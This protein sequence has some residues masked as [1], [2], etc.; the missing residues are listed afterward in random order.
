MARRHW[1]IAAQ[2][3]GL[4][5]CMCISA[6]QALAAAKA[7]SDTLVATKAPRIRLS[8]P[9]EMAPAER[10]RYEKDK[11]RHTNLARLLSLAPAL[12]PQLQ[13]FNTAMATGIAIPPLEREI[14]AFAVLNM[15]RG[16]WEL[17][18][19][20]EVVKIMGIPQAKVD[21][22]VEER[23]GDPSFTD[24]ERALLAFTRQV[25][26]SVRVDDPTFAAVAAF[27]DRRQIVETIMVITNYMGLA[28]LSEVA[29]L[30]VEGPVGAS[31]WKDRPQ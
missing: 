20:R 27:Y 11:L 2:Q 21:A 29:E 30:P 22:V 28:R 10:E 8:E 19:H 5:S 1:S 4:M 14:V 6:P 24:R 12:G 9:T 25:V 26:K 18:Q 15:E 7:A 16:D 17:V 3:I 23:Y 13:A 31:F